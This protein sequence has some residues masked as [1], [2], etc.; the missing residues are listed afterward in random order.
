[1]KEWLLI[2][3]RLVAVALLC[4]VAL[5][6]AAFAGVAVDYSWQAAMDWRCRLDLGTPVIVNT[7]EQGRHHICS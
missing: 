2:L 7:A 3:G 5:M 1:M 4:V 6:G